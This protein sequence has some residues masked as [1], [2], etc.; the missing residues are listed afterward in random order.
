M[1]INNTEINRME[2][3]QKIEKS[4]SLEDRNKTGQYETPNEMAYEIVS[5]V[6]NFRK[7]VLKH[8][9]RITFLEPAFGT[10]SFYSALQQCTV[11]VDD[12]LGVEIDSEIYNVASKLWSDYNINLL[13]CDFTTLQL[14]EKHNYNLLITNPPYV[15][16]HHLSKEKKDKLK[17]LVKKELGLSISGYAGL[18]SYFILLS[19]K[20]LCDKAL[21]AWLIPAEFMDVNYGSILRDYLTTNVKITSIH[22]YDTANSLFSDALVSSAVIIYLNEK[23]K[24]DDMVRLSYGGTITKP[25]RVIIKSIEEL[26]NINKWGPL[27]SEFEA[28]PERKDYALSDFFTVKRGIATGNNGFFIMNEK[29]IK[30]MNFPQDCFRPILPPPRNLDAEI[31]DK[32]N[33]G[34]PLLKERFLVIDTNLKEDE[35]EMRYPEFWAYLKEGKLSGITDGYLIKK[36][37]IWYSQEKR[38]PAP[39]LCTYMGRSQNGNK[40]FKF[41]LNKSL[42]TASNSYILLYPKGKLRQLLDDNNNAHETVLEAL[43]RIDICHFYN[44]GREYG[45]GLKKIEPKEL[46]KVH[47]NGLAKLILE[48]S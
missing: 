2:G 45:G 5:S 39:F 14:T 10:G 19:H 24:A 34:F 44:E 30:N 27:F 12:S 26:K 37:K 20:W 4:K 43:N 41:I 21:C 17:E 38:D 35:I 32:D 9:D 40:P 1:Q 6:L 15:R 28:S 23:P 36:R 13:N 31:I 33:H 25:D 29:K 16:H 48:M 42:A 11:D 46:A 47:A 7:G 18:Y 3:Q 8:N 22:K